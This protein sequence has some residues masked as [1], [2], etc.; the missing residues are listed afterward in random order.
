MPFASRVGISRRI[1]ERAERARLREQMKCVLPEKSGG[2]IVRTVAEDVTKETFQR[3]L[4]SLIGTWKKIKR[5]THF[6]RAPALIHRETSLAR[7][8]MRDVFTTKVEKP[9]VDSRQV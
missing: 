9:T 3:D 5:K 2:V 1:C 6:V 8:L 4:D 7:G